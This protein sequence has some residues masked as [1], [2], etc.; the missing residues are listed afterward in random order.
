MAHLYKQDNGNLCFFAATTAEEEK[1][2]RAAGYKPLDELYPAGLPTDADLDRVAE[3][4]V[5]RKLTRK[6]RK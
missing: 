3:E 1:L 5:A 6:G 4:E 2:A